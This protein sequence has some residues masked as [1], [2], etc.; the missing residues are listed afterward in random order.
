MCWCEWIGA[1]K[2]TNG[3]RRH[4][5]NYTGW[6]AKLKGL[7][8]AAA[9]KSLPIARAPRPNEFY[10]P[11]T[12]VAQ[13]ILCQLRRRRCHGDAFRLRFLLVKNVN[14]WWLLGAANHRPTPAF[15]GPT[16]FYRL[17]GYDASRGFSIIIGCK[18]ECGKGRQ[19]P[20]TASTH[21]P[22]FCQVDGKSFAQL[23]FLYI[24]V[25]IFNS[26]FLLLCPS[27][28]FLSRSLVDKNYF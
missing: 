10:C 7:S 20:C 3:R 1:G 22:L 14:F 6:F 2:Q 23:L 18:T 16:N 21:V 28:S 11:W 4:Q 25:A 27:Q 5:M 15:S 24:C 9:R 17:L 13:S 8:A 26:H 12:V 19:L